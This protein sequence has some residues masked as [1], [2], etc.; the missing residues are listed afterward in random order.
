MGRRSRSSG[1]C[2][3][4]SI[5]AWLDRSTILLGS[6]K[7]DRDDLE[8]ALRLEMNVLKIYRR[9]FLGNEHVKAALSLRNIASI[10]GRQGRHGEALEMYKEALGIYT[11]TSGDGYGPS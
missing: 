4:R 8:E 5:P 6:I 3:A 7:I 10:Y 2:M 1:V 9:S 11:R